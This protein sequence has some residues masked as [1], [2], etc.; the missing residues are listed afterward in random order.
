MLIY[1]TSCHE[2]APVPLSLANMDGSLRKTNKS[3]LLKELDIDKNAQSMLPGGNSDQTAYIIDL[4]AIIQMI[5]KGNMKTSGELSEAIAAPVMAKFR[6]A[7]QVHVVPDRYDVED[8]IKAGER[9]RRSQWRQ[10]EVKI[11]SRDTKLPGSLKRYLSSGKN[12]SN[13]LSFLV[14]DWSERL[15]LQLKDGQTLF[16][17]SQDGKAMK[18]TNRAIE[19]DILL[20]RSEHEEADSRMFVHCDYFAKSSNI[21]PK[22]IVLFSPDTDVAVLCW[23]HFTALEIE[24][25]WFHTGTGRNKK[26]I[27]VHTA[28]NQVGTN[29]CQLL[30][31]MHA[32]S[33]CD[34]TSSLHGIGK[35]SAF[36]ALIKHQDA[37]DGL[38]ELGADCSLINDET[39]RVCLTFIGLLYGEATPELNQLRYK[40]FTK[41]CLDSSK[42]PPTEESARCHIKR[43]NYQCFIWKHAR[44]GNLSVSSPIANGWTRDDSGN[45][46]P[47]L[48]CNNPA[49]ESL[50]ELVVCGCKKG[51]TSRCSCRKAKLSCTLAC[52]CDNECQNNPQEDGDEES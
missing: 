48:M 26:Y 33:G 11:H 50:L 6:F 30:P 16:L 34:S 35:K 29:V 37:L 17:A 49:P 40:L 46:A 9:S 41:K 25:F 32:L 23:H 4:L 45:L 31:A 5:F 3:S 47:M 42:L 19:R 36:S 1:R 27:P 8:S 22:R 18:I 12:K 7:S 24:E 15:P 21:S 39:V 10:I 44:D 28:A 13:L 43:A 38:R 2:L 51:C 14:D 20:L 52:G